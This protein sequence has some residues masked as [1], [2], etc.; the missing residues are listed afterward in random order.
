MQIPAFQFII[1]FS[2]HYLIIFPRYTLNEQ[3]HI[4]KNSV[5]FS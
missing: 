3:K 5:K 1:A 2:T 4:S